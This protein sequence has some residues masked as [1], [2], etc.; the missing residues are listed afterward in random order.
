MASCCVCNNKIDRAD[1]KKME[2]AICRNF[3]HSACLKMLPVDVEYF[4]KEKAQWKCKKCLNARKSISSSDSN[5]NKS[6][7]KKFS[8]NSNIIKQKSKLVKN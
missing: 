5:L 1:D 8:P 3:F 4:K 2:C 7:T 6:P